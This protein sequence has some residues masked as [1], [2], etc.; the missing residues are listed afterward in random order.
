[1][2]LAITILLVLVSFGL[3]AQEYTIDTIILESNILQETREILMFL[4]NDIKRSEAVTALYLLDGEFAENRY[5]LINNEER[6]QPV[7]GI[8]IINTNR[9]KDLL[10]DKSAANFHKFMENELIPVIEKEFTVKERILFGHSF[11]GAFTIYSLLNKPGL[12]DTYI[13]SSPTPIMKMIDTSIYM[14][15]DEKLNKKVK[16][17]FSYGSKDMKQV[18]KWADKLNTNLSNFSFEKLIWNNAVFEGMN[19]NNSDRKAIVSGLNF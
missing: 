4:P 16:F 18:R 10:P 1:M 8:G 17:Y 11:A 15:I 3:F 12:F 2:K 5:K 14:E 9:N 6:K 13:A 7:I 19:H